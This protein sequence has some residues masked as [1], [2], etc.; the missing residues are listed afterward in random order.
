MTGLIRP[1][2]GY[3]VTGGAVVVDVALRLLAALLFG[4]FV[5]ALRN[6]FHR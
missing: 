3:R 4:L 1:A 2:E 6:R 5:L